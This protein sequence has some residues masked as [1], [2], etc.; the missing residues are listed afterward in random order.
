MGTGLILRE[1]A[2]HCETY[3]CT[4]FSEKVIDYL[5]QVVSRAPYA[6]KV[7]LQHL[8]AI[9][10]GDMPLRSFDVV[11]VN[12]VVQYFPSV[13]Y[14]IEVLRQAERLLCPG[15]AIFVGDVR[16]LRLHRQ[17]RAA[18]EIFKS[19]ATP[20]PMQLRLR[21]EQSVFAEIELLLDPDFFEA[22]AAQSARCTGV[23]IQ[24]RRD[25]CDNELSRYRYDVVLR[26]H[27]ATGPSFRELPMLAWGDEMTSLAELERHLDERRPEGLRLTGVP[28]ARLARE[29]AMMREVQR[30]DSVALLQRPPAQGDG[31]PAPADFYGI[32]DS[33]KYH[34]VVTWASDSSDGALD[35]ILVDRSR[36]EVLD[37]VGTYRRSEADHLP[38][39]AY[40]NTPA[41]KEELGEFAQTLRRYLASHLPEYMVPSALVVLSSL[42]LNDRGK[43]NLRALPPPEAQAL[44]RSYAPP[45]TPG[46]EALVA[47]IAK[48]LGLERVGRNDNFFELGG[49]SLLAAQVVSNI[50][51]DL[52]IAVPMR[53]LFT[54]SSIAVLAAQ[55]DGG[56]FAP[57]TATADVATRSPAPYD[58]VLSIQHGKPD[59]VPVFCVPGAGATIAYFAP[60][61]KHLGPG[62]SVYGLQPKGLDGNSPPHSS[63][64]ETARAYVAA[65]EAARV[66]APIRLLGH[67]FGGLVACE[68]ASQMLSLGIALDALVLL[69]PAVLVTPGREP[70]RSTAAEALAELA[71]FIG[72]LNG[73]SLGITESDVRELGEAERIDLFRARLIEAGLVSKLTPLAAIKGMARV[74]ETSINAAYRPSAP[75]AHPV[76]LLRAQDQDRDEVSSSWSEVAPELSVIDSPGDHMSMLAEPHVGVLAQHIRRVWGIGQDR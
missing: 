43:V 62:I 32:A 45:Q 50:R 54:A 39:A 35:V 16:N 70:R 65:I 76:A 6:S 10:L 37:A 53:E 66:R 49:H 41:S 18:V 9:D 57:V 36:A 42:P 25:E 56:A 26:M 74:F 24:I 12:S 11:V 60:L 68:M 3:Y 33:R 29:G 13:D 4:D 48:A 15:G 34:V 51:R 73:R 55:I 19:P 47:L 1:L 71:D 46:E 58:P 22:Y 67:S 17:F 8:D 28:N 14:L 72:A 7:R 59:S 20:N 2:P 31:V 40:A 21:I 64:Q 38:L 61:A 52:R 63:V 75:L 44:E 30:G 5:E 27:P 23:D 69:D